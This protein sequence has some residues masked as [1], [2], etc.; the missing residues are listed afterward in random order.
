M[1][2]DKRKYSAEE[3][4]FASGIKPIKRIGQEIFFP[5]PSLRQS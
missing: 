4:L 2:F 1:E 3:V 5:M